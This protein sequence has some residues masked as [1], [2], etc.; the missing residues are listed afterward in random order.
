MTENQSILKE[1]KPR[2]LSLVSELVEKGAE[3]NAVIYMIEKESLQLRH[4]I[5]SGRSGN[6]DFDRQIEEPANDW[7][8]S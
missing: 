7:P 6:L 5:E 4:A 1:V 3:R 8:A 2:L